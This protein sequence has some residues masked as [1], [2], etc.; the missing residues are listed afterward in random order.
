ME[1]E[2]TSIQAATSILV[3]PLLLYSLTPLFLYSSPSTPTAGAI[4]AGRG[5]NELGRASLSL[6]R[7]AVW[8]TSGAGGQGLEEV[9]ID[10]VVDETDR[11]IGHRA[12]HASLMAAARRA[13]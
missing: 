1:P 13:G 9:D 12:D 3:V 8:F 11:A 5:V 6:R 7:L 2:C 10:A 4:C